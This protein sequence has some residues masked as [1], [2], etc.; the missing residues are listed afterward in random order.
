[1]LSGIDVFVQVVELGGFTATARQLGKSTSFVS[2]EVARL[3]TRLGTRLLNRTTRSISLTESGRLYFDQCRQIVTDAIEAE[4][5]IVDR[6]AI[7]RGTLKISAPVSFGLGYLAAALPEFLDTYPEISLDL[8]F[9][10]RMVDIVAEGFDVVLRIGRLRDSSLIARQINTSRSLTVAAPDYWKRHGTPAHPTDLARHQCIGYSLVPFPTRWEYRD[11][12][13]QPITVDVE[14]RIQCNSAELEC[15][16]AVAGVG[17][18]R[19]PEFACAEALA[20]GLLEPV[21]TEFAP[22][23]LGIYAIYP[24]RGYLSPK[25]RVLI[26]FLVEKFSD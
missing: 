3:E 9:N 14:T 11:A 8:E 25:V 21:L 24:Q 16:L 17:V 7:P 19:M 13:G 6:G 20:Q 23:P 4:R 5:S 1:M 2:K 10:D 18:T 26:D 12:A 15:S 22:P